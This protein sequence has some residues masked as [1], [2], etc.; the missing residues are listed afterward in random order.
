MEQVKRTD[1][2]DKLCWKCA[3]PVKK[4]MVMMQWEHVKKGLRLRCL[5]I[6]ELCVIAGVQNKEMKIIKY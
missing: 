3:R 6:C 1:S 4:G 5:T 2:T